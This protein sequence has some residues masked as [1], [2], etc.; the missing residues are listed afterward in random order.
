MFERDVGGINNLLVAV[1][2]GQ[3]EGFRLVDRDNLLA[4]KFNS[5]R[6][7]NEFNN[8]GLVI[9]NIGSLEAVG[10]LEI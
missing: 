10:G 2:A 3:V 1:T 4:G 8:Y 6:C 7:C 5:T 9:S